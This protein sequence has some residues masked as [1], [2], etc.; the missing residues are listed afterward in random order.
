LGHENQAEATTP[1]LWSLNRSISG[2]GQKRFEGRG[3][4]ER[5]GEGGEVKNPP[6]KKSLWTSK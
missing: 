2:V 5:E 1:I 6:P 4:L 3:G